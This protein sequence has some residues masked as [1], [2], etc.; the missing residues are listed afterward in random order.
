MLALESEWRNLAENCPTATVFQT[1]EWNVTWWRYFGKTYGRKLNILCFRDADG[2]LVG[3][4]PLMI[5]PYYLVTLRR[6]AFLGLGM[7]DYLDL[8]CA[9]GHEDEVVEAFY[10]TISEMKGWDLVDLQQLRN[11]GLLH[12]QSA[13]V[14]PFKSE[15]TEQEACPYIDLPE[16]WEEYTKSLGKKTRSNISYHDRGL[17]K[18]Y[19]VDFE[20]VSDAAVLSDEM[21]NLYDLHLRRWNQRWLP[22]VFASKRVQN[23]H[24]EVAQKLM[25][26]GWLR[27]YVLRLDGLTQAVLYCFGYKDRTCYYQ[28]GFEPSLAKLSLGTVLTARAIKHAIDEGRSVFDFLRGDEP[29][30]AKWTSHSVRNVR[31]VLTRSGSFVDPVVRYTQRIEENIEYRAKSWVRG[32]K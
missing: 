26:R 3:L 22:G 4:A 6:V 5:T 31:R 24:N 23:F 17:T 20:A 29:Y 19:D 13:R 25:E 9:P 10:Q 2:G 7:S 16:T 21:E 1:Y 11:G 32:L 14:K 18:V 30:K 28:G 15:E 8:L 27:L 12:D